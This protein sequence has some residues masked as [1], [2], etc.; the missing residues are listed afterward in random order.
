[1]VM[2]EEVLAET[3][4]KMKL[5]VKA[6]E[7]ELSSV[8]TGRA[9]P[10]LIENL[11]VDYYGVSTPIGQMASISVP[12][13]RMLMIQPWDTQSIGEV[14]QSIH[15]SDLG[16]VP[17]ND[18]T[19]IRIMIPELTEE[20]R[21][22]LVKLVGRKVED[23]HVSARNVRRQSL[24]TFRGMEHRKEISQDESRRA[25]T[26]LQE[27]TDSFISNMDDLKTKKSD[28]VMEI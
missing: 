9:N 27:L 16:L 10:S 15:K 24:E 28:E 21:M 14:E 17:N 12:E 25:Q 11:M 4:S 2:V 19:V 8:R 26:K 1:M 23:A 22:Q 18:G 3:E 7:R 13:A 20:R 5:S 6:F